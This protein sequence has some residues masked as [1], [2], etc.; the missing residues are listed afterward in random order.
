MYT[1]VRDDRSFGCFRYGDKTDVRK[2]FDLTPLPP[3]SFCS[4]LLESFHVDTLTKRSTDRVTSAG[5]SGGP[6]R[7]RWCRRD[8]CLSPLMMSIFYLV[9]ETRYTDL[10]LRSQ[11]ITQNFKDKQ[12]GFEKVCYT[13][14]SWAWFDHLTDRWGRWNKRLGAVTR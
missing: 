6:P 8:V 4:F 14:L 5:V 2:V 12:V 11:H 7:C 9:F 13:S 10:K 1:V 3:S